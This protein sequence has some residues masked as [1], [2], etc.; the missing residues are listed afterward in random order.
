MDAP[1]ISDDAI[2]FGFAYLSGPKAK[3][4]FGG[5]NATMHITRRARAALDEL[6]QQ[7]FAVPA[8]DNDQTPRREHY[9]GTELFRDVLQFAQDQ[10]FDPFDQKHNWPTFV[11]AE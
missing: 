8:V 11:A 10:G 3:L 7:G 9:R 1:T 2:V 4:S 5:A 6:L